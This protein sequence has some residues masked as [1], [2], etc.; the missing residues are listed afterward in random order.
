MAVIALVAGCLDAADY[1]TSER[2]QIPQ[3]CSL[4]AKWLTQ[5]L[6]SGQYWQMTRYEPDLGLLTFK[7][8][9]LN[10]SKSQIHSN[11]TPDS[12]AKNAHFE[13]VVFTLRSLVSTA[14]SFDDGQKS[15]GD[16]CTV[17]SAFRYASKDGATLSSSGT[18][19]KE[20]LKTIKNSYAR[21]GFDY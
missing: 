4:V 12:R 13:G 3:P 11:I 14:L 19:E 15:V 6:S 21:N 10:L 8:V 7:I 1:P 2:I 9:G 20:L 17:S 5:T 18:A 16:S